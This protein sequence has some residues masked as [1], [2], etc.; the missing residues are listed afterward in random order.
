MKIKNVEIFA[1]GEWN[2][3]KFTDKDLDSIVESFG[4]GKV[5]FEPPLKLGHDDKQ[6]ILQA[7][8]YPAAGW[9]AS[10]RKVGEKLIADFK[11]VPKTIKEL[12][13]KKAYKTV[14]S[15]IYKDYTN[16]DGKKFP[17]VLKAVSLLGGDIPAVEGLKDIISLY[18][19]ENREYCVFNFESG[20]I[21]EQSNKERREDTMEIEKLKKDLE[22]KASEVVELKK[23]IAILQKNQES[24]TKLTQE[25]EALSKKLETTQNELK[26]ETIKREK[27]ELAR[28]EE[29]IDAILA[30]FISGKKIVPS[31][32][33]LL[34]GIL[35]NS[36]G[37]KVVT[38]TKGNKE[39]KLNMM[40]SIE[41]FIS[42]QSEVFTSEITKEGQ[43]MNDDDETKILA[44][45]KE[46]NLDPDK[47]E[48]YKKAYANAL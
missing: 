3:N 19:K 41:R 43:N 45:C 17:W 8:G 16:K 31:Q 46:H 34:K 9:V 37:G 13:E 6:K 25:V 4:Q 23:Q 21:P 10:I 32:L 38:L 28:K 36:N 29:K 12:I 14:S 24:G 26:E 1:T 11:D 48:D 22:A 42:L 33:P 2:G 18:D 44:Y 27:I 35:M 7:D 20:Y 39:E 5:G 47:I 30:R 15:E 40:D